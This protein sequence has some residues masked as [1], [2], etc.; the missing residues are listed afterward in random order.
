MVT[1]VYE[2]FAV[3]LSKHWLYGVKLFFIIIPRDINEDFHAPG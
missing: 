1:L 2:K 3:E